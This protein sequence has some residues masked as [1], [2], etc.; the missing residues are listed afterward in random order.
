MLV[1]VLSDRHSEAVRVRLEAGVEVAPLSEVARSDPLLQLH[2][3]HSVPPAQPRLQALP[4]H[5]ARH[6]H[7]ESHHLVKPRALVNHQR[8][9]HN[10]PHLPF[11]RHP[12]AVASL[13][14]PLRPLA[15]ALPRSQNLPVRMRSAPCPL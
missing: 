9:A 12:V 1:R 11:R 10:Q 6:Q 13:R 4:P 3:L 14:L 15:Q 5:L 7:L 8:S 2:P